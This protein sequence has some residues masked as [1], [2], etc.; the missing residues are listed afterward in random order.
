MA[1][2]G[3]YSKP[4]TRWIT[5]NANRSFHNINSKPPARWS[6]FFAIFVLKK[7]YSKPP[8]RWITSSSLKTST[9]FDSKPPTRWITWDK[10]FRRV[11]IHSKP[12]TRWITA[13]FSSSIPSVSRGGG[14]LYN[15]NLRSFKKFV[16]C[17]RSLSFSIQITKGVSKWMI[18]KS[19]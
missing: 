2:P 19:F 9:P 15:K 11:R 1:F 8:T 16:T 10:F 12:P 4:P 13:N 14:L 5:G 7:H 17:S 3:A 18:S 6:T